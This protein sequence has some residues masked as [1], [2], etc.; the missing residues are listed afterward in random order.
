MLFSSKETLERRT[1]I[2]AAFRACGD[3]FLEVSAVLTNLLDES[4]TSMN[5]SVKDIKKVVVEEFDDLN[6]SDM[7]SVCDDV[8]C[9]KGRSYASAAGSS[10]SE[11][12]VS[13]GPYGGVI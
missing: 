3:A 4:P 1:V 7:L 9:A 11:V 5:I 12:R 13:R 8:C 2:E 6:G 10:G